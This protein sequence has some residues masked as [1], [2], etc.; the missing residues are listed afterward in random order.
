MTEIQQRLSGGTRGG[1]VESRTRLDGARLAATAREHG[2]RFA[3]LHGPH[4]KAALLDMLREALALPSY[5]G[6]NWDALEE[7]LAHPEPAGAGS[8]LLAWHD[9]R[10]LPARD[11]VTFSAILQAA[12]DARARAG[13]GPLVVVAGPVDISPSSR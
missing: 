12:T 7:V 11:A 2:A 6:S 13:D 3:E 5:T 1:L 8:A 9:P 4:S 10:R